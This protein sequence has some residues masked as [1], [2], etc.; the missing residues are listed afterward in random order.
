YITPFS[1]INEAIEYDPSIQQKELREIV[2]RAVNESA[3][4]YFEDSEAL[5]RLNRICTQ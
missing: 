3:D 4:T 2:T 1:V 5:E